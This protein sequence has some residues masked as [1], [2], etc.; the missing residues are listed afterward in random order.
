M[1][2]RFAEEYVKDFN[3]TQAAIRAGY[4]PKTAAS[5]GQR[6]LSFPTVKATIV[7]AQ[8]KLLKASQA[9]PGIVLKAWAEVAFLDAGELF[10]N[11]G[12]LR[13]ID[14]MPRAAQHALHLEVEELFENRGGRR[15]H[16]GRRYKLNLSSRMHAM[17]ALVKYLLKSGPIRKIRGDDGNRESSSA[18]TE[19]KGRGAFQ[20][21]RFVAEYLKDF[22]A[23]Q[24]AIRA[25]YSRKT[26]ASQGQRL[27]ITPTVGAAIAKAWAELLENYD[28]SIERCRDALVEIA[29][30]DVGD[31]LDKKG[32][33]VPIDRMPQ[34]G[35]RALTK[36]RFDELFDSNEGKKTHIGPNY[37]ISFP[38]RAAWNTL[39]EV[40]ELLDPKGLEAFQRS[41]LE[42][43][44][45]MRRAFLDS[46]S[47]PRSPTT[48]R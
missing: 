1:R 31:C 16:I 10:D 6:L 3:A 19:M 34:K 2:T 13:P 11:R 15:K 42:G 44:R 27:L 26:A 21:Q 8:K 48:S 25:G 7:K 46:S 33:P 47:S 37:Q 12:K 23:T 36:V 24:A 28:I 4:S 39:A 22:N 17:K 40:L 30:F 32:S 5:Q 38:K 20:R 29:L 9:S 43:L 45:S 18:R 14:Q 35:R 41:F